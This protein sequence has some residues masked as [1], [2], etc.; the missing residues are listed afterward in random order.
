MV[1]KDVVFTDCEMPRWLMEIC[2]GVWVLHAFYVLSPVS[3]LFGGIPHASQLFSAVNNLC[4]ATL[5]YAMWR[6]MRR[7]PRPLPVGW[8]LLIVL[9]L[10]TL[11]P[12][13]FGPHAETVD[14][15]LA[16]LF[17]LAYVPL[18]VLLMLSYRG[19]LFRLGA[20]MVVYILTFT[21]L[22]VVWYMIGG[23]FP[24]IALE[25]VMLV[26]HLCYIWSLRRALFA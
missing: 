13:L 1:K 26:V 19:T 20:W 12:P 17:Q 6:A 11:L 5:Y 15:V 22:P 4:E 7:L 23:G 18:G 10:L 8:W 2:F 14:F 24:L 3:E 16:F 9:D 25:I 21:L